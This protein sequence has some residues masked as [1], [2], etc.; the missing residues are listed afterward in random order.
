MNHTVKASASDEKHHMIETAA[1]YRAEKRGFSSG[2]PVADWIEAEREINTSLQHHDDPVSAEHETAA[3]RR[4]RDEFKRIMA[5]TQERI[6]PNTIKKAFDRAGRELKQLGE[7]FPDTVDRTGRRLRQ[8][9][10]AAVEKTGSRW[11]FLA[12]KSHEIFDDWKDRGDQ[13]VRKAS[14]ALN[15]WV[16]R[17]REKEEQDK[18]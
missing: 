3:Y 10:A 12:D 1:Y 17:F 14:T 4:S 18:K 7:F 2:D 6:S 9:V 8:E 16:R 13:F 5:G 11:D 15:T